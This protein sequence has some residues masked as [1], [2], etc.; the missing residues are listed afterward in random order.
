[1]KQVA[2]LVVALAM[3]GGAVV[4]RGALDD[5]DSS[6]GSD[7]PDDP[8]TLACDPALT[9]VCRALAE[10]DDDLEVVIE[11]AADTRG[12]LEAGD[13]RPGTVGIDGW[14]TVEPL[15]D[16]VRENRQRANLSVILGDDSDVVAR[17]P[18]VIVGWTDRV[19]ALEEDC[20]DL[21][22]RCIGDHAGV[23]WTDLG[24][25]ASWGRLEPGLDDIDSAVGLLVAGQIASAFFET[26]DFASND[27]GTGGFR[28]WWADVYDAVPT[29]PASA[30]TVLDQMLAAGPAAYDVLGTTEAQAVTTVI[31][32]RDSDRLTISYPSPVATADVVLVPV[33][34]AA[35]D[36][37][38][39]DLAGSDTLADALVSQGWR[40]D[41]QPLPEGAD[42]EVELPDANGLPRPG[43]LEALRTL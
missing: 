37:A 33:L 39:D 34:D 22:W 30:D 31:G 16:I 4:I 6:G 3:I 7:T 32:S 41:G 38:I 2:A 36:E 23:A 27:F 25:R 20:P 13:A 42:P 10:D 26:S 14:L 12:R 19:A 1:M 28:S 17:S 8:V 43:V 35:G 9:E 21:G 15:P 5:R 24:G 18:L 11:D 40:V 29:F